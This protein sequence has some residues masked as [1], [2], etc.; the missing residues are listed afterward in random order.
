[1]ERTF[2]LRNGA[3]KRLFAALDARDELRHVVVGR[4]VLGFDAAFLVVIATDET[5]LAKQ[6]F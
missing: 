2:R 5:D 4:D 3:L 1:M 6:A